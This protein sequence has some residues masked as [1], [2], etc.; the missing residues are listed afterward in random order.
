MHPLPHYIKQ[1]GRYI[2]LNFVVNGSRH[3]VC[4][5]CFKCISFNVDCGILIDKFE[6]VGFIH[7]LL[8]HGK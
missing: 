5:N 3:Y 8:K 6:V 2:W 1:S 7:S 4:N